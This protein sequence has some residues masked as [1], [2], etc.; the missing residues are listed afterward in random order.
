[1]SKEREKGR[2]ARGREAQGGREGYAVRL[3]VAL[4]LLRRRRHV[5]LEEVARRMGTNAGSV[6]H[7]E[8][9]ERDAHFSTLMR[10]LDA[11]GAD[12]HEL[13]RAFADAA[14]SEQKPGGKRPSKPSRR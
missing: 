5:T 3:G 4:R 12:L 14:E 7:I 10:L 2:G 1:M 9:G 11:L 8:R 13:A 6:S